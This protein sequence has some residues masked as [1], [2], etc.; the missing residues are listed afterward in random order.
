MEESRTQNTIRNV[1]TGAIVQFINKVMAFVVR[2]VFIKVLNTEYLGVNGLFTN[3]LTILS[4]AEL[5]IGTAIIFSMYKPVAE[6][7]KSKIKSLMHL[8]QKSYNIIGIIVFFLGMCVIPFMNIIIKEPPNI[9]EN[10][11]F[12]YLLFLL[13][14]VTSYFFT[15]KKSIIYAHQKQSIID[16][17]DSIVYFIKSIFEITLLI[18]TRNF[19]VY[20]VIQIVGTFL[21]NI[22]VAKK[23]D[24][25]YPYLKEKDVS[26]LSE[27]EGNE[28]LENVKSLI[29]YKLGGV[30]MNG[31]DN[32]LISSL[33]NVSTVGL[34]S[35][36]I[37]IIN[38]VKSII[39]SALNGVTASVGNLNAV[40]EPKQ[41]ENVFYQI[42]FVNYIVCSFCAI[43][44]I[45]LLNPF[46]E[47]WIGKEYVM[48][49]SIPISLAISFWVEGLRNPGY[50]YRTTLGLFKKAKITP[51]IGAITNIFLSI[52]LCRLIG[53]TG[54]FV[55]TIIAQLLSYTWIDPYLIYKYEFKTPVKKYFIKYIVYFIVFIINII[56]SLAATSFITIYGIGGVIIK[57]LIICIIPNIINIAFFYNIV[58]FKEIYIKII[59]PMLRRNK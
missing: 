39:F 21:E 43:A 41:K 7:D 18:L 28:I 1:K 38:S 54:I 48:Q 45:V 46:I 17:I 47:L 2:T 51:Y 23:A 10:I 49:M 34:C 31:T 22:I 4:F 33:V 37:L 58:E 30:I 6:N 11:I 25:M 53:V 20:L 27:K 35:N 50:T 59:I 29:I 26:R 44:F 15:Y 14:T 9:K 12:I 56:F 55:A 16:N 42:T 5:G 40:G 32:I 8:Y 36:Y 13:N 3:I 19:I 24:K 57:A 52:F